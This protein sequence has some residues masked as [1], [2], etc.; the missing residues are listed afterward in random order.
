MVS[1]LFSL[2]GPTLPLVSYRARLQN[3]ASLEF[4]AMTPEHQRVYES[5]PADDP[6]SRLEPY[7]ELILRWRR[8]GRSIRRICQILNEQFNFNIGKTALHKYVERR[9]PSKATARTGS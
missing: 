9:S 7:R 6:R 5:I 3:D 2:S 8:Q 4:C 1:L